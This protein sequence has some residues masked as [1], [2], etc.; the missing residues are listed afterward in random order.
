MPGVALCYHEFSSIRGVGYIIPVCWCRCG[1]EWFKATLP[2]VC[3]W[4]LEGAKGSAT[5]TSVLPLP[6]ICEEE[7][8]GPCDWSDVCCSLL[9]E[10]DQW[11]EA[12]F[13]PERSHILGPRAWRMPDSSYCVLHQWLL[14]SV[15]GG[16]L[17]ALFANWWFCDPDAQVREHH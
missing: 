6:M 1:V 4:V 3:D 11:E 5:Q 17:A 13:T 2:G 9:S 8:E 14:C 16:G 10:H 7:H 12:L 15:A